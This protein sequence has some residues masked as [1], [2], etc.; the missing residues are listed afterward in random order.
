MVLAD[1]GWH[2][3]RV[4]SVDW[5][6]HR[7][8]ELARLLELVK[9]GL[10][11]SSRRVAQP[12][13]VAVAAAPMQREAPGAAPAA[14]LTV[15]YR[16][17]VVEVPKKVKPLELDERTFIE[18][19]GKV[20]EIESPIRLD[21]LAKRVSSLFKVAR[22]SP[23]LSEQVS[24]AAR[25]LASPEARF[26][27]MDGEFV[28]LAAQARPTPRNRSDVKSSGLRDPAMLPP[29]EVV[30]L[31]VLIAG[32]HVGVSRDELVVECRRQLGFGATGPRLREILE[33]ALTKAIDARRL[34]DRAGMLFVAEA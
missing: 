32:A 21:E 2:L 34:V 6:L 20:I 26:A 18:I 27:A 17:A 12:A 4:W 25:R 19:V 11:E 15:P 28:R 30:E 1:R 16:E 14:S 3:A 23:A 22:V 13:S 29:A 9:S 10:Q 7:D 5:W 31:C 24:H 33:A 8:R